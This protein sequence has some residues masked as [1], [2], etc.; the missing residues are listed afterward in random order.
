MRREDEVMDLDVPG[1]WIAD[2][3]HAG[4]V[5]LV[6]LEGGAE[7][8]QHEVARL[9]VAARRLSVGERRVRSGL[10]QRLK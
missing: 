7:I 8:Q 1:A 5:R 6:A 3:G 2:H 9:K 10:H 4:G